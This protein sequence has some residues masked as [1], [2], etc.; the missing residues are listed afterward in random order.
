MHRLGRRYCSFYELFLIDHLYVPVNHVIP[1]RKRSNNRLAE[2]VC[3][4]KFGHS[5]TR[6]SVLICEGLPGLP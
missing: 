6:G 3:D 4:D 5:D 2:D 1:S